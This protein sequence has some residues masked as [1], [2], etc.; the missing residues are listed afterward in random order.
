MCDRNCNCCDQINYA[1]VTV[2]TTNITIN[3][4]A[5]NICNNKNICFVITSN[6][7]VTKPLP[8]F[9][10]VG[11]TSF[12]VIN[13]NGNFVYSDQLRTRRLYSVSLKTDTLLA[14]NQKCN[15]CKTQAVLP[16]VA[17]PAG[18]VSLNKEVVE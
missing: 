15:L 13:K 7:A 10:S 12:R 14:Q 16:C 6:F 18:T 8:V 5:Q 3:I 9:M 2:G 1:T 11:T 4:P 17:A